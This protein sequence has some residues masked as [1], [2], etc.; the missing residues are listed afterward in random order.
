MN[1]KN[2]KAMFAKIHG[3]PNIGKI[4]DYGKNRKNVTLRIELKKKDGTFNGTDGK[5]YTNPLAL[6]MS[7][8]VWNQNHSDSVQSG[9]MNDTLEKALSKNEFTP[10]GL[11]HS[12]MKRLL[13]IWDKH[14]LN[15]VTA[16]NDRQN[17]ILEKHGNDLNKNDFDS[18]YDYAQALLKKH[19]A[20]PHKG[21]HYGHSWLYK[22]IPQDDIN[23]I[24]QMQS[25]I[26][27]DNI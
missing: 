10:V 8:S 6:S 18:H 4:K 27:G 15:D 3:E 20:N 2:R 25:K 9:Q 13:N 22:P 12:E 14:H 24:R 21:Y 5:K 16:G 17:E 1:D 11:T 23:F 26:H 19:N 7:A